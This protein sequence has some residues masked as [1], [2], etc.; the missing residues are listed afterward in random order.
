MISD[1]YYFIISIAHEKNAFAINFKTQD[2]IT[3]QKYEHT[4]DTRKAAWLNGSVLVSI[5]EVTPWRAWLA[6][7]LAIICTSVCNQ[8]LR[9]I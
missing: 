5:N 4:T 6:L 8:P 3:T 2:E 7:G 9:P 1:D